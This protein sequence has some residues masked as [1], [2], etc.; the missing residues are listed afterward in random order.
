MLMQK[1]KEHLNAI[2]RAVSDKAQR[3]EVLNRM[4]G[5][6]P[7]IYDKKVQRDTVTEALGQAKELRDILVEAIAL[8]EKDRDEE[9]EVYVEQ[10]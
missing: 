9:L 8:L 10:K 5:E 4:A 6:S 1:E 7:I 2:I 3:V